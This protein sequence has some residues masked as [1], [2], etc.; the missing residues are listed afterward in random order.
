MRWPISIKRISTLAF[1]AFMSITF[2]AFFKTA[3]ELEDAEQAYYSQWFRLGYDDQPPFYTWLQIVLNGIFG[4]N[5]ISFS[6]LRG[7]LFSGTLG[8]V[9]VF[10]KER[11]NGLNKSRLSVL[12]LVLMP[13]FIDFTFRRLSHTTLLCLSVVSTYLVI[14][15][16]LKHPSTLNYMFLGILLGLGLMSKYNYAFFII[17]LFLVSLWDGELRMAIWQRKILVSLL[18]FLLMLVPH[19]YWLME[20][21]QYQEVLQGSVQEKMNTGL[22]SNTFSFSPLLNYASG[23][24]AMIFLITAVVVFL[25]YR[26]KLEFTKSHSSWLLKLFWVQLLVMGIFFMAFQSE[27]VE[28][29]WMLPLFLPF[30]VLLMESITLKS[31]AKLISMGFLVFYLAI[32]IQFVR[33]PIE[34]L[35][36]IPSSVHFGFEPIANKL[37]QNFPNEEWMLP[38]VTYGGNIRLLHPSKKVYASDD[39]SVILPKVDAHKW[40]RVSLDT[41]SKNTQRPLDSIIG[42]GKEKENLYF[43]KGLGN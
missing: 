21:A 12:L 42:F 13:V 24:F 36:G 41:P 30:V 15:R 2:I 37:I 5:S 27:K 1:F 35:F 4:V 40:I 19:G 6:L 10:A 31:P 28:T 32:A 25:L 17:S 20:H 18:V 22:S 8:V 9:Y 11:G 3:M 43:Y 33:T 38:N 7:I 29:R 26:K 39:Y 16:L 23:L 34:K 14:Q